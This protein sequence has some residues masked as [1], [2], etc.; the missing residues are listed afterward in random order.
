MLSVGDLDYLLKNIKLIKKYDSKGIKRSTG[1][2]MKKVKI[3]FGI[4]GIIFMTYFLFYTSSILEPWG[5]TWWY[6]PTEL[7]I[8]LPI[9]TIIFIIIIWVVA[10]SQQND[11]D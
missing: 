2:I 9:L 10:I 3:T 4:L 11:K 6:E 1:R 7:L 5:N 8:V